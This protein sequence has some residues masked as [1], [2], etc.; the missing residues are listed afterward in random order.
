MLELEVMMKNVYG[1]DL[2]YPNCHLSRIICNKLMKKQTFL[3]GDIHY[4]KML[5]YTLKV[6]SQV[7]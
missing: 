1:K 5:G 2:I 6:K 3:I 4:L 7:F